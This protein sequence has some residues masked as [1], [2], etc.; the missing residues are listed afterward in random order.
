LGSECGDQS[1]HQGSSRSRRGIKD[2]EIRMLPSGCFNL[3]LVGV[4]RLAEFS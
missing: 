4:N 2:C 3:L 1:R